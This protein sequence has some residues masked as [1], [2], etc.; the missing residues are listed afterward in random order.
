MSFY[1]KVN[2]SDRV[3]RGILSM[4]ID[5][6][7]RLKVDDIKDVLRFS[8]IQYKSSMK[9]QDLVDIA[10][11]YIE[12]SNL[13][14]EN[15]IYKTRGIVEKQ[16]AEIPDNPDIHFY[17]YIVMNLFKY[18]YDGDMDSIEKYVDKYGD[19]ILVR[20]V[21]HTCAAEVAIMANRP[22]ILAYILHMVGAKGLSQD[23][24]GNVTFIPTPLYKAIENYNIRMVDLVLTC[25]DIYTLDQKR[26]ILS[27]VISKGKD[28]I[29][30]RL[31]D[32]LDFK[33]VK[34]DTKA[35]KNRQECFDILKEKGLHVSSE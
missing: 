14:V 29:L 16:D 17:H 9:K 33:D 19:I 21:G 13:S 2:L 5:E 32:V 6:L 28:D 35:V 3:D 8:G 12:I 30:K 26:Y 4:D 24:N 22:S 25:K 10:K 34:I 7:K 31:V 18:I 1:N 23:N 15:F 27:H 20:Y 11:R